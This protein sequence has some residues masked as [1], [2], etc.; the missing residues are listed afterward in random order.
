MTNI[1]IKL[2]D[3]RRII[4]KTTDINKIVG[5]LI[6]ANITNFTI[7]QWPLFYHKEMVT[8]FHKW[9][10]IDNY[11]IDFSISEII[12]NYTKV[13]N[14]IAGFLTHNYIRNHAIAYL[15]ESIVSSKDLILPINRKDERKNKAISF[16]FNA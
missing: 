2:T 6:D 7:Q 9:I 5:L 4:K 8:S 12:Y 16:I 11:V 15:A 14:D 10:V 1:M 13:K 3:L